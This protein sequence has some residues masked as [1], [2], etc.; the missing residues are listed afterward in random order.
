M[1]STLTQQEK[2]E[3]VDYVTE[4]RKNLELALHIA[5]LVV[6]IK[7][8]V[9]SKFVNRFEA[10][11]KKQFNGIEIL[12]DDESGRLRFGSA[13]SGLYVRAPQWPPGYMLGLQADNNKSCNYLWIGI[14]KPP[15]ADPIAGLRQKLEKNLRPSEAVDGDNHWEWKVLLEEDIRHWSETKTLLRLCLTGHDGV[16]G[17]ETVSRLVSDFRQIFDLAN[18]LLASAARN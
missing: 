3:I 1:N 7:K 9:I 18:P 6:D 17:E 8:I 5:D 14:T 2:Q 10:E 13:L 4:S 16:D 15:D 11:L 12:E